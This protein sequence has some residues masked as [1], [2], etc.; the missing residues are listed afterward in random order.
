MCFSFELIIYCDYISAFEFILISF[1]GFIKKI[2]ECGWIRDAC[3]KENVIEIK[4]NAEAKW[5]GLT[6]HRLCCLNI[7]EC[8]HVY[9]YDKN[10]K[11]RRCTALLNPVRFPSVFGFIF[12]SFECQL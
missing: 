3:M 7:S 8:M 11:K 6:K 5:T 2:S 12:D 9:K 10:W 1:N 4:P